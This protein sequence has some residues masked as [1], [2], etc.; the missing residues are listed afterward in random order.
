[1]RPN[2]G[3]RFLPLLITMIIIVV[4]IVALISIGRAIFSGGTATAPETDTAR[5]ALLATGVNRSVEMIVRGP[6]VAEEDFTSYRIRVSPSQR[7]MDVFSG[8]L[9]ERSNGK[10]LDNNTKAYEQFVHALDKANMT[11]AR[12][13]ASDDIRGICA[14]GYVYEFS[15][16]NE[17]DE[18]QRLWTSTCSGSK[19]SLAASKDQLG[20]LFLNQI[21]GSDNLVPFKTSSI[22]QF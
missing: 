13:V 5:K 18:V 9:D 22:L 8:Y 2:R 3:T 20:R 21:P 17:G 6:I 16:L 4:A 7:S 11:Q 12:A 14:S 19:G 1:M 15:V 10:T